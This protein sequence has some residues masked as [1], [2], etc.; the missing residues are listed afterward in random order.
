M[1]RF[2][3]R[4]R[5]SAHRAAAIGLLLS[6]S[7]VAGCATA[8]HRYSVH[9]LPP[10]LVAKRWQAPCAVHLSHA[11][12][13]KRADTIEHGDTVEVMLASGMRPAD[14]TRITTT[15]ADDGTVALPMLGRVQVAGIPPESAQEAVIQA[16]HETGVKGPP[17]VQVTLQ[18]PRQNRITVAGAVERPGVYQLSRDASDVVSAIAAAGG[19]RRDAAERITIQSAGARRKSEEAPALAR[20]ADFEVTFLPGKGVARRQPLPRVAKFIWRRGMPS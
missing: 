8:E 17:S 5:F 7:I 20:H 3:R 6:A 19:L 9:D 10:E 11:A 1:A 16:C 4:N 14:V 18:Q 2:T 13:R 15:V 12:A